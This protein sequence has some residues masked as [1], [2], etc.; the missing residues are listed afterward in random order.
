M[1]VDQLNDAIKDAMRNKEAVKRDALRAVVSDIKLTSK[2][3]KKDLSEDEQ[4]TIL[5]K[6]VKQVKESIDAYTSGNRQDLA[7]AEE[8]K[9][10]YL[11]AFLPKQ[12][13]EEEVR[14]LVEE[15]ITTNS[16]DTSNKGLLMK[17]LMPLFK[18]KADGKMV[19][20]VIASFVK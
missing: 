10:A 6:H 15:T 20:E 18:G 9:L 7:T 8:E 13:S 16:L 12:M 3:T 19:N 14:S 4:V 17:N 1:L 5:N 2:E 11:S